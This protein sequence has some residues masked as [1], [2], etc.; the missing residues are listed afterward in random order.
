MESAIMESYHPSIAILFC[1]D[2]KSLCQA[3]ISSN[4]RT[5]SIHNSINSILFSISIQLIPCHS[6]IPRNE[7]TDKAAKEATAIATNTILPASFSSSIQVIKE[8]IRNDP[9]THERVA[10]IYQHQKSFCD[11]K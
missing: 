10:L 6:D 2:S 3:L 4:P 5:S 7:L 11:S 8:M 1:T 9:R